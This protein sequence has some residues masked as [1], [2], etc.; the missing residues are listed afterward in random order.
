MNPFANKR[1][2]AAGAVV[3]ALAA[4][5]G[6]W[7]F[8]HH[9]ASTGGTL[10]GDAVIADTG[11]PFAATDCR[12]RMFEDQPALAVIFS[13]PVDRSQSLDKVLQVTDLGRLDGKAE[14]GEEQ[15]SGDKPRNADKAAPGE[16][17]LQGSWVVD[18]N[19]RIVVFPYIQPQRKFRVTVREGVLAASGAKLA[20][21]KTCELASEEMAPS[22]F[23]ASKGT[24]LPAKQ[25]GGL[26][27]VTVNVPEV[28]VQ[29]LRVE[30]ANLP[31]FIEQVIAGRKAPVSEDG[32]GDANGEG[33]QDY[34][35]YGYEANNRLKGTVGTW[36]LDRLRDVSKSVYAGRF[37]TGDKPN[38]RQ[39]TFLPVEDVKELQEPGVYIAVMSQPGRFRDQYQV[40]YF[41]V[42]DIGLHAHRNA[43]TMDVFATSLVSGKAMGDIEVEVLDANAKS[44][45]KAKVD[46]DGHVQIAGLPDSAHLL[47]GRRGKELSLV[48]LREPG[49][50]LS[51]F[52]IGGHLPRDAKLF[53]YAGRDLY[54]PGEKFTAS[55]LARDADGRALPPAP[56]QAILKRPDG[57][58]VMT[59]SWR[60][61]DKQPGYFQ[62]Q[63]TLPADAQTGRWLLE[64]RAD[65]AAKAPDAVWSFQV[66]E[67]LPERMK[68]DLKTDKAPL[69]GNSA[70]EV[71]VQG[72]YLFGAPA[73]GNRL[74]GS[75]AIERA[76]TP[77]TK[78]W[79]GFI[80]GDFAD[81]TLK[82]RS[83]MEETALDDKGAASVTVPT[84]VDSAKSPVTVRA[85]F[86]LLESGG[87]P[88]VRSIERT[89]W[90]A[91]A[92]IGIRPAFD[93]D[94]SGEEKNADF[95]L[96]RV[97]PAGVLAPLAQ[98]KVRL[99]REDRQYYW[100]F[101]DQRGW[102]SGFTETEELIE[103]G[104][105]A[106]KQRAKLSLP[107]KWGRYRLEVEDPDT[108]QTLRYRFYAGWSAQDADDVG[109]R[110]DR[111]QMK[112]E[113]LP[114][115]P[116]D[117]VRLTLTPPHDGEALI[118]VE[119]D[120]VLWTKRVAAS[121]SGTT[122]SIPVDAK[123]ARHDLY[124]SAVVFRPG[125]QGDRVTPARAL[126]LAYLPLAREDRRLKVQ[127]TAPD[128]V[129]PERITKVKV[130]VDGAAGKQATVTLSAVDVGILNITRY[131]TP[132][133]F[134]F[135]FG[136][137]RYAP[138]LLDLYGKLIEKM[139]GLR[140]KLKWGGDAGMRDT[141]SMPK[142]VKLVD[143]FSGPVQ[144]DAKGEAEIPLNIPDFNG[145]LRLMAVASTPE[146]FGNSEREMTVAA[147]IVAEL[148]T[149]RFIA[150]GDL[151]TIALDV[152][153][154]SGAP[155]DITLKLEAADPATIRDGQRTLKLAD[156]QRATLRFQAEATDAY[157]LARVTLQLNTTGAKPII[158]KR[159]SAL[160]VQPPVPMERVVRRVRIEPKGTLKLDPTMIAPYFKA[161]SNVSVTLSNKPP[162]NV[163]ALVKGLLDYPYGCLEQ[164]TSAAYP[165]VFI[166]EAGAK[167]MGLEPR[168]REQRAAFIEGAIGR[169]SGMQGAQGG[170][171][172]WGQG[173]Y[174]PWLTAYVA[175]FLQDSREAGFTVPA[176]MS[177]RAQTWMLQ[178]L[179]NAPNNFPS[180]PG[181]LKP[182]DKGF[183]KAQD[184]ELLR[185][186]HQRFAEMAHL[187][188]MLAREQAAPLAT[189]RLLHDQYR[190]RAR[191]PLP[192]VH[193]AIAL[194]LSGDPAR[195]KVA[196]NEAMERRYGVQPTGYYW[197]W[198]GDYGSPVRDLALSYALLVRHKI[199]HP[200]RE[201]ILFDLADRLGS[202]GGWASTQER[203]SLFLAA[204]AAGGDGKQEWSAVIKNGDA[205]Q[206]L[207]SKSTEARSFDAAALARG[208]QIDSTHGEALFVE[209]EASGYPVKAPEPKSD[210]I[211]LTRTWYEADGKEWKG[212]PL[213]VGDMMIVRVTASAKQR[214]EDGLI[215]DHIP[216]GFE[217][218]NMNLSQGPSAQEFTVGNINV[219]EAMQD[220]RI[221]HREF[222]DDRYVA[223]ARIEPGDMNV[224]Y[225]VRVVTPGRYI[226]PA[227]FA[228]D[229]YRPELRGIGAGSAPI[230]IVDPRAPVEK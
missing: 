187:A 176:E 95:E 103:S 28:D 70:F 88:V 175:G 12:A 136:K 148:A 49:L 73:A 106:L 41:Y 190:D 172:L 87:R 40:T 123:W 81:D 125:S 193:L 7:W 99:F 227:P 210:A 42:S 150:P 74:L 167:A 153:N 20:S 204:R 82:R 223:A 16:K 140:G 127:V 86:S 85:S 144:L 60:P 3:V 109:N 169:I 115:K 149:P 105:V 79:P 151:A 139:D 177:K 142:K 66:E 166:D 22:Y 111:V 155:Q 102:H 54:R 9:A 202:R 220:A 203:L 52:D 23:F 209:I 213:K 19:P 215:V 214:I 77:F 84:G 143:L 27:V 11:G 208:V 189:L 119:G 71:T 198:L 61:N 116:G 17:I 47:L 178:Q 164:T 194:Q 229:M 165:H 191:S 94:V 129:Q 51:E 43:R 107:V 108:A 170:F 117:N 230:T 183:Y 147:P 4:A 195:A 132:D 50:D 21:G 182:D 157:G 122:V 26:P 89:W 141:K 226:V 14:T 124:V 96:I 48:A 5:G 137:H 55:L 168:T 57:R 216:A 184:Y 146:R 10:S 199:V 217:V 37:L 156:K 161:S 121:T 76:R 13:E 39:V 118:V 78:E 91:S 192:L 83:E 179:Q 130:K 185:N 181:T 65:P 24:V 212:R 134:D 207:T 154:L 101:D 69:T 128:K 98:A 34:S 218:E 35:E 180:I 6:G 31:R 38:K 188:Y 173:N 2:L 8:K 197:E 64:V 114:A 67:F 15:R 112:L 196:L 110:P 62:Q 219:G 133:P 30:P 1:I 33:E 171:T 46:G 159:E 56:V 131:K 221:K 29:F 225:M 53:V 224:F 97:T 58:A 25:N 228:E 206:T 32:E 18:S 44:L 68:L 186:G 92:M 205:A 80:F 162:L 163:K 174:E 135:F 222:R 75:V 36:Q 160:Q 45:A 152:T 63:L 113:G 90:P 200:R 126:G 72:D 211:K 100:R 93:R 158:I 59:Q 138:E 120:K 201:Q 145:T 104:A